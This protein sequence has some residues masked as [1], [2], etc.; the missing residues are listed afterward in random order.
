LTRPDP[1]TVSRDAERLAALPAIPRDSEGPVFRAPWEAHAFAMAVRLH[2]A[3]CFTWREWA[4]RLAGEI[5]AAQARGDPDLGATY[6]LH[7]LAALE[8][9]VA[10]KGIVTP[11]ALARRKAE[12]AAA[13]TQTPRGQPIVLGGDRRGPSE[14]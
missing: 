9:L 5:R 13:A 8:T 11:D 1:A 6:Y 10:D 4:D 2:A 14:V 12:W 7:W 3:G